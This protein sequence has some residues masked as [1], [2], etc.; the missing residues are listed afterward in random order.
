MDFDTSSSVSEKAADVT[1]QVRDKAADLGRM[2]ADKIDENREGAATRLDRAAAALDEKADSLPGG[3][4]VADMAH[5][6]AGKVSATADYV[7]THD[8]NRMVWDVE[9]LV[10]NNPGPSLLAA[11]VLGFIIGRAFTKND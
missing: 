10:K 6:A 5:A 1:A 11:A 8:A 3:E 2:A 7:R 9:R 4:R